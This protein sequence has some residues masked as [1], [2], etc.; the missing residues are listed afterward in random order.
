VN[1]SN[2]I[3]EGEKV[4]VREISQDAPKTTK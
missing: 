2:Q 3:V 1:I 4:A